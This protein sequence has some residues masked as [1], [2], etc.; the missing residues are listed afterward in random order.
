M[1]CKNKTEALNKTKPLFFCM[2]I[3]SVNSTL[4]VWKDT[5][6]RDDS[7]DLSGELEGGRMAQRGFP[8]I[9]IVLTVT[10]K[11]CT[12]IICLIKK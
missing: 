8:F 12:C 7:G 4:R 3:G 9:H 10:L 5:N 2:H 6:P 1:P 11:M